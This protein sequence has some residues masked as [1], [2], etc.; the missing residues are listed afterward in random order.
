M[1]DVFVPLDTT[2]NSKYYRD[3]VAK[4]IL[5]PYVLG[6]IDTN[7]QLLQNAY[8]NQDAFFEGFSVTPDMVEDLVARG[9]AEGVERNDEQLQRSLPII[10]A[11]IKGLLARD[12]YEDGIYVR[13]TNP[14]N[15]VFIEALKVLQESN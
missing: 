10:E 1:P 8:P 5:N 4:N 13:A 3:L 15:P 6:Y 12:L 9:E 2:Y 11:V 14:L 7:R